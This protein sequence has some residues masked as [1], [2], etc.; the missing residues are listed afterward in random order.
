MI[1]AGD[2]SDQQQPRPPR[3]RPVLEGV[4]KIYCYSPESDMT[5][6]ELAEVMEVLMLGIVLEGGRRNPEMMEQMMLGLSLEARRHFAVKEVSG[7]VIA[8]E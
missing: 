4:K 6:A 8:R 2:N 5:V 7:I 3:P 1:M